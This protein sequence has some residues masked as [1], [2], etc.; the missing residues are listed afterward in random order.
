MAWAAPAA[1]PSKEARSVDGLS[2]CLLVRPPLRDK[3]RLALAAE[4]P[5]QLLALALDRDPRALRVLVRL[6]A[7]VIHVRV[8]RIVARHRTAQADLHQRRQ[9]IGDLTQEVFAALFEDDA[10]PLRAWDPRRGMSLLG[11]VGLIAEHQTMCVLRSGRRNPWREE[12]FA[13]DEGSAS[14]GV[15]PIAEA[16]VASRELLLA[17]VDRMRAELTPK[18]LELFQRIVVDEE[19]VESVCQATGLT[20]DAVYAWRSRLGKIARRIAA[21]LDAPSNMSGSAQPRT[22]KQE[23]A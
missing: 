8:A 14:I 5:A 4:D 1:I 23:S 10:R 16:R 15:A 21:D 18:A 19:P 12:L 20:T 17:V 2:A 9:Q 6:L 22:Y 13:D 11:Y 3:N 7:P